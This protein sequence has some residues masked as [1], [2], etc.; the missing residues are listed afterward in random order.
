[1]LI[2]ETNLSYSEDG[3]LKYHQSRVINSKSWEE[4]IDNIKAA[5]SKEYSGT[6]QGRNIP[7]HSTV[8][9]LKYDEFHLSCNVYSWVN[10]N[11]IKTGKLAYRV[12]DTFELYK[13]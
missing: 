7:L 12:N 10:N 4:Y 2:I 6:L 9:D 3:E 13:K 8:E 11:F 1:M 5:V